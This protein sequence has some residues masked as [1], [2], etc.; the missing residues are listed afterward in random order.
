MAGKSSAT[1]TAEAAVVLAAAAYLGLATKVICPWPASSIP[2]TPVISASGFPFSSVA[3]SADAI[4]ASF[5]SVCA[6]PITDLLIVTFSAAS[7]EPLGTLLDLGQVLAFQHV[8]G[9]A[10]NPDPSQSTLQCQAL[11][12]KPQCREG[13]LAPEKIGCLLYTS[14]S[15]RDG[16]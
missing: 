13:C 11:R 1:I 8:V 12:G 7:P 3:P 10:M 14:P 16:L 4:S 15:P 5:I 6:N 9:S 2:A